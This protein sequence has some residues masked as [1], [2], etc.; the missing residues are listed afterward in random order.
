[1]RHLVRLILC[2]VVVSWPLAAQRGWERYA[3]VLEDPPLATQ[4]AARK[5]L[6]TAAAREVSV[7]L[8]AAQ[9]RLRQ[10]LVRRDIRVTG[11]AKTLVNA[12]FVR[13]TEAQLEEL[14]GLPGVRRVE[15]LLP[16]RRH[17]DEAVK[18]VG[19]PQA[20]NVLGGSGSAGAGVKIG[21]IDTG[22]D[23]DH[24]AFQDPALRPPPGFPKCQPADCAYTNNKV[25]VARSYVDLLVW[26]DDPEVSRPD[27]LSPRDRV[28]HGTA[29]A[30]IAAGGRASGP[31]AT[32]TGMAP[33]AF[34]GNYKVFGSP[35]VNDTTFHEALL[36]ALE[37][38]FD[39]GMDIVTMS[40][41]SPALYG[42]LETGAACSE[43]G[44]NACDVRAQAVENAVRAG[45]AV[46]VSAGND[47]DLG[48]LFP[49]LNTLHTPGTAP[50]AITVGA[51][52]N[53]HVWFSSV[54]V[55][56]ADVPSNL[57]D[58][59]AR[60]GDGP[61]P[62]GT[63]RA[64][65]KDVSRTEPDGLACSP[66]GSGTLTGVVAL[67]QRGV[68]AFSTKVNN[69]QKAGAV[70][71]IIYQ[72]DG[73]DYVFS[74]VN[75]AETAIPAVM[76]GNT[77]GKNLK[78]FLANLPDREVTLDPALRALRAEFDTVADFSSRGPAIGDASI[79]PELVAVGTD[80]YTATQRFDPNGDLYDPSGFTA[81]QGTSFSVPMVAGAAALV[82]QRNP[83]FAAAQLKSAVVNT[84]TAE[85][86]DGS[87]QARVTAVGAGK[88]NAEGAVRTN[89]TVEPATLSFGVVSQ[90]ALPMSRTL[91]IANGS[92]SRLTVAVA[93][94]DQDSNA[95]LT[96][97]AASVN[98][99]A[100]T[101]I[102]VRLEGTLPLPGAYAGAITIRGGA[103][104]LRVPY[105][106]LVGDGAPYNIFPL[107][108]WD[109]VGHV[110]ELIP[111]KR[112]T[113][114]LIDRH[115]V[116][117]RNAPVR[118]RVT[119]G[120]GTIDTADPQTDVYGI[121]AAKVYLGPQLGEQEFTAEAGGLTVYFN[122]RARVRPVIETN[123]V[124]NAASFER[125]K[126]VAPGSYIAIFG[127]GLSETT[128]VF[129]TP[130]LPLSLARVS[131]SFDV[132]AKN[133]SLP[134]RLHFV[135]DSQVNVQ[136]PWELEGLN[137]VWIKVSIG[138][139]STAVYTLPLADYSPAFFEYAE[140]ASGRQLIAALDEKYALVGTGNPAL[141]GRIVQLYANGLGPV[142]NPP[143]SGEITPPQPLAAT[144]LTPTLTVGG[145]PATVQFSGL[146]PYNVGLYQLNVVVPPDAPTGLQAVVI[147]AGGVMS[148][149]A[150]LPIQ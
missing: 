137:T 117:V 142:D 126:A 109:F 33:K 92:N 122:G 43:V 50:S 143:P 146:A 42:A 55:A 75:L 51:S 118:F 23:Q 2:W 25:I 56:G 112:I 80:L 48:N 113:L 139:S 19:A 24:P 91:K 10:E 148:K 21:I 104:D 120:G 69:A 110:S 68:C 106:Y 12:V 36:G 20:W 96:L 27:D 87:E 47:G 59:P 74:P 37:D 71:A 64:P 131:V 61:R 65:L 114:K 95:R 54:R 30:M 17:L 77:D 99:G 35:G 1:M 49:T 121:A 98:E 14:R 111:G 63:L 138:D 81:T 9:E 124:V 31:S 32:I 52:T 13:A 150:T 70:A 105:L 133:L 116:P 11:S 66:V 53:A 136:A 127:R 76:I 97:S 115:G 15:H 34:L 89:V 44:A 130:Y 4:V 6:R 86:R 18:L 38:A 79:K 101:T 83:G 28:G 119:L 8:E 135:S 39:D 102:S 73:S 57:R 125:G 88:L 67:I 107:E 16:L 93:P 62:A 78:G 84:A 41:G 103:V 108:G 90:G 45:M 132:P 129:S 85:V 60:F 22:I 5:D 94:R 58:L 82:K 26:G 144:R 140:P 141:R 3:L 145:R 100:T 123:G 29:L 149:A 134:G 40:V 46:V 147:S 7:R 72:V 128:R